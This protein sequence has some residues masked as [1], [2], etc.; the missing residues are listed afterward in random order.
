MRNLFQRETTEK[1]LLLA[2]FCVPYENQVVQLTFVE[3]TCREGIVQTHE[4]SLLVSSVSLRPYEHSVD[5]SLCVLLLSLI[6]L[7]P[8]LILHFF[9]E[10]P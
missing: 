1:Q 6:T 10:I 8:A 4:K 2:L 7:S 3:I 5:G 9:P